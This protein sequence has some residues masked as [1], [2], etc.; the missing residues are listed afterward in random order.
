M[1]ENMVNT[2]FFGSG[3][4]VP[5]GIQAVAATTLSGGNLD[6]KKKDI[7]T[8]AGGTTRKIYAQ[9]Y[10]YFRSYP[11]TVSIT[12]TDLGADTKM[13]IESEMNSVGLSDVFE[14][15]KNNAS[16]AAICEKLNEELKNYLESQGKFD[17]NR[18]SEVKKENITAMMDKFAEACKQANI[19]PSVV[20]KIK[21]INSKFQIESVKAVSETPAQDES[22]K[23][24]IMA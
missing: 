5:L 15:I 2:G 22:E 4:N 11:K 20:A 24:T 1:S 23:K 17:S 19:E 14:M 7:P 21:E 18:T 3:S 8:V 16:D 12:L 13:K 6:V 9:S 10:K